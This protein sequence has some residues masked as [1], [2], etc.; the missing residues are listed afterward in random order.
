MTEDVS[1][2]PLN[3]LEEEIPTK[4]YVDNTISTNVQTL[5][6]QINQK[7]NILTAG[8]NITISNNNVISSTDNPDNLT[9]TKT[10]Q[11]KIQAVGVIEKN[12]SSIKFDWIGTAQQYENGNIATL[13]P[14][15]L[16]YIT[17]DGVV[18]YE[19]KLT[20]IEEQIEARF[21]KCYPVGS[22]YLSLNPSNPAFLF[23]FGT[24][25][26]VSEGRVLQGTDSS[27]SA[28]DV[29]NAAIP[30]FKLN[31]GYTGTESD[32]NPNGGGES[33]GRMYPR[34]SDGINKSIDLS[35]VSS[36]YQDNCDTVQPPAF[37]CNIWQRIE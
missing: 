1:L 7:Q 20:E 2:I 33:G 35:T 15:W 24:W 19:D 23:G 28:G 37:F 3:R 9:I 27:H 10:A 29:A 34:F 17:N 12:T 5:E 14:D 11:D 16:C 13:H 18:Y 26:K 31:I 6:G 32:G 8:N 30:N 36:V 25:I 21:Q 22:L 4:S